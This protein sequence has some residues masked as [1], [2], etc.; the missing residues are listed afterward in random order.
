MA[1][2]PHEEGNERGYADGEY[3]A[4]ASQAM[5]CASG[6]IG[7]LPV[8]S[9]DMVLEIDGRFVEVKEGFW[10]VQ[11]R[12]WADHATNTFGYYQVLFEF[13]KGPRWKIDRHTN[14]NEGAPILAEL[15]GL[16]MEA[17]L[18]TNHLKIVAVG[19]QIALYLNGEP[20]MFAN[21]PGFDERYERGW[22][23]LGT[24]N[25]DDTP[26]EVRWDNIRVWDISG[27]PLP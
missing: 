12:A 7:G 10:S 18:Q 19:P 25:E 8:F 14:E 22:F 24:C 21:D 5:T 11:F 3:Y 23:R 2:Q 27:L 15:T 16:P 1:G 6:S 9:G 26:V 4:V 20:A 17:G 13:D